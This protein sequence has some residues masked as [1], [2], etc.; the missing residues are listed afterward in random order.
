MEAKNSKLILLCKMYTSHFKIST[1][2]LQTSTKRDLKVKSWKKASCR[3]I[4]TKHRA[5]TSWKLLWSK[6]YTRRRETWRRTLRVWKPQSINKKQIRVSKLASWRTRKEFSI[7]PS[8][9]F[10]S[11]LKMPRLSVWKLWRKSKTK[12]SNWQR[13]IKSAVRLEMRL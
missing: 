13:S 2:T 7:K 6:N 9:K 4:S 1:S 3:A 11:K 10:Q 8:L 12:C 5:P